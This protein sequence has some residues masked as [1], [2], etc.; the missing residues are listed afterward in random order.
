MPVIVPVFIFFVETVKEKT[1]S[2]PFAEAIDAAVNTCIQKD[3]LKEFFLK[4]RMEEKKL[5]YGI[6]SV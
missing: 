6:H 4:H 1:D 5:D 2:M 3:V